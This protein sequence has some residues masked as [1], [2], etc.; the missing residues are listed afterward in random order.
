MLDVPG[1]IVGHGVPSN[2]LKLRNGLFFP[3]K[4]FGGGINESRVPRELVSSPLVSAGVD[5]GNGCIRSTEL[6]T[7]SSLIADV[8]AGGVGG[9]DTDVGGVGGRSDTSGPRGLL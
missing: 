4:S 7:D 5:G 2:S 3:S 6:G 9:P 1:P 8:V